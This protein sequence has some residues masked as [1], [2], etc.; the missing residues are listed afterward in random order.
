M[1]AIINELESAIESIESKYFSRQE[2]D[3]AYELYHQ[4]RLRE[5]PNQVEVTC[6]TG[7]KRFNYG[8]KV[9]SNRIICENFFKNNPNVP[10]FIYRVPDLL[11]HEYKNREQQLIAVEIKKNPSNNEILR[12]L[13]KLT[14]YCY[15]N[16]NYK[17]GIL[18][19][20]KY[21]RNTIKE[22]KQ[23]KELLKQYEKIEIWIITP[24]KKIDIICSNNINVI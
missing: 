15:G 12:D 3:F 2:R 16:L 7:K 13:S 20:F 10:D 24:E 8:D 22:Y 23:I 6:E 18:M 21:N 9:F 11:I 5:L 4:M 17:K 14:A 1:E 19:L